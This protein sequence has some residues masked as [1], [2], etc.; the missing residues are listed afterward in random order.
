MSTLEP[1]WKSSLILLVGGVYVIFSV[2]NIIYSGANADEG[3]YALAARSVWQGDLPYRDF[4]YTQMP[5]LPYINGLVMQLTGFGLFQQRAV[6]GVWGALTLLLAIRWLARRTSPNWALGFGAL[7]A[8]SAPWMCFVHLGKTY[9]FAG[10]IIVTAVWIYTESVPSVRKVSLLALCATLGIGC[11]LTTAPFFAI[12][13]IAAVIELPVPQFRHWLSVIL[14]SVL[15]PLLLLLPFYLVAPEAAYFWTM[16]FHQLSVPNKPWHI[17]WP[18]I[19]ALAPALWLGLALS[20][21]HSLAKR[22]AP[23]QR[24][25]VLILATLLSLAANLLPSGVYEEYGAPFLPP[26]ALLAALGLWR[27]GANL[28][29]LRHVTV[30]AALLVLNLTASVALLWS[31]MPP[32]RHSSLSMLLPLNAAAYDATL[33]A[34]LFQQTRVVKEYLLPGEPFIGPQIILAVEAGRPVPKNLR[35]GPFT[36][37]MELPQIRAAQLNLATFAELEA[38]FE[39]PRVRLLS[40]YKNG[41]LNY[42]WSMPSFSNPPKQERQRWLQLIHREFLVAYE[43]V[44]SLLLIRKERSVENH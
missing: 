10:L 34:R 30:P 24:E 2:W 38:Y 28:P 35:M 12:L 4:G 20:L 25:I 7:L 37:T 22:R 3:F 21:A 16:G 39:D 36:A 41:N 8:L 17:V 15:W 5:L 9:A 13:W 14:G 11:R 31:S 23:E 33:P 18:V 6:N 29:W 32:S 1:R 43:D 40:F 26:L 42:A 19:V 44:D 27:M